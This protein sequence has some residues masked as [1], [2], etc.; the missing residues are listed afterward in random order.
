MFLAVILIGFAMM[1]LGVAL[2]FL[3]EVPF[4]SGKRIPARRSRWI[5]AFLAAYLP[6]ALVMPQLV[7]KLLGPDVVQG[8][9]IV[10][11]LLVI[12]LWSVFA[13]LFRVVVP[14]HEARSPS[15][16]PEAAIPLGEAP[17]GVPEQS[18]PWSEPEANPASP[19]SVKTRKPR[20]GSMDPFDFS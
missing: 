9:V 3:G 4:I 15:V 12:C 6:L 1:T 10:G 2:L 14:K 17:A 13:I 8:P 5:G 7:N 19:P 16:A 11:G 18:L 20:S